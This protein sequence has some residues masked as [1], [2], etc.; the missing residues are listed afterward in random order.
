MRPV[1]RSP[2]DAAWQAHVL[3]ALKLGLCPLLHNLAVGGS[4]PICGPARRPPSLDAAS[5]RVT[6]VSSS[7]ATYASRRARTTADLD[8]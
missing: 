6:V 7:P 5:H 1:A 3:A 4:C 8:V 2:E